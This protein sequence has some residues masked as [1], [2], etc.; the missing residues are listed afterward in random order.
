MKLLPLLF[1]AVMAAPGYANEIFSITVN[2][3]SS[4]GGSCTG[5]GVNTSS[6]SPLGASITCADAGSAGFGAASSNPGIVGAGASSHNSTGTSL[7][8]TGRA[9]AQ[10]EDTGLIFSTG[11]P[12]I[13][14]VTVSVNGNLHGSLAVSSSDSDAGAQMTMI[15]TLNGTA[16]IAYST[17]LADISSNPLEC[18]GSIGTAPPCGTTLNA[19]ITSLELTVPVNT[20]LDF[21][22]SISALANSPFSGGSASAEFRDTFEFPLSGPVFNLPQG[23]TVN[24]P[25]LFIVNNQ[26]TP[27][28]PEPATW[29]GAG[30]AAVAMLL[31]RAKAAV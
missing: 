27:P 11:D 14:Q 12:N 25:E 20:P 9:S 13:K 28:I 3:N 15:L 18:H 6:S 24:A 29:F 30:V 19:A 4:L 21:V 5:P 7:P 2:P 31:R 23:V 10:F 17:S 26:F 8:A 22:M 16:L 1:F